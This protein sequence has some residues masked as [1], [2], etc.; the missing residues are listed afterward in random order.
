MKRCTIKPLFVITSIA[1]LA[2]ATTVQANDDQTRSTS[3]TGSSIQ[4]SSKTDHKTTAFLKDAV[5][6]NEAEIA[7]ADLALSKAQNAELKSFA[8]QLKTDHS[9][10]QTQL[11]TLAQTHGVAV[12]LKAEHKMTKLEKLSGA[13]FDKE[14]V[15]MALKDHQKDIAK[16]EKAAK[17]VQASDVKSFAQQTLPKLQQHLQHAATV[18]RS[19]G[20]DQAT[21]SSYTKGTMGAVGGSTST[22]ESSISGSSKDAGAV[23][24]SGDGATRLHDNTSPSPNQSSSSSTR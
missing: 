20:I 7:M 1:T 6:D 4:S 24:Q 11:T 19:V 5:R 15:L 3:T 10:A 13:D 18:A 23:N 2:L 17:D 21:I 9:Q 16:Y 12:D 14:F 8:Q 22:G